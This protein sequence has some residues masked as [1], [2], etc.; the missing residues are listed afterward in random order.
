MVPVEP[1]VSVIPVRMRVEAADADED[2]R[3][4]NEN[5]ARPRRLAARKVRWI[6]LADQRRD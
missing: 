3:W 4:V 2:S 6:A 5:P 1:D